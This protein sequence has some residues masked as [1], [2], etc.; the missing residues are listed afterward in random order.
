MRRPEKRQNALV[1]RGGILEQDEIFHEH[2]SKNI[3]EILFVDRHARVFLLAEQGFQL[4][5]RGIGRDGDDVRARRHDLAHQRVA[6]IDDGF[7]QLAL[8]LM[9]R[10]GIANR[11]RRRR[12]KTAC[13]AVDQ[14]NQ[15]ERDR[16]EHPAHDAEARQQDLEHALRIPRHDE[17]RQQK[18]AHRTE[19]DH[20][21]GQE[22]QRRDIADADHPAQQQHGENLDETQGAAE[23]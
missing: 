17:K 21:H 19:A 23:R 3:V 20:D 12:R 10:G 6:E 11:L 18:L 9:R 8:V 16:I 15:P 1:D 14:V 5:Q 4:F 22:S 2:E 7:Q 13:A